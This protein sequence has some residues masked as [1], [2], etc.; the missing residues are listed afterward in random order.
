MKTLPRERLQFLAFRASDAIIRQAAA[1]VITWLEN[2][3]RL[4]EFGW[5][6]GWPTGATSMCPLM[7]AMHLRR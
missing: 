1:N 3:D 6:S 7:T 5:F 4:P 2:R